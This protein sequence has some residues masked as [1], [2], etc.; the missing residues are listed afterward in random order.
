MLLSW[1]DDSLFQAVEEKST[2]QL[3]EEKIHCDTC[4]EAFT[5][6][7]FSHSHSDSLQYNVPC[8]VTR[9]SHPLTPTTSSHLVVFISWRGEGRR[10]LSL[11]LIMS[12]SASLS[13][14]TSSSSAP[15]TPSP[16]STR[17]I[18]YELRYGGEFPASA[19]VPM[20]PSLP[21]DQLR[22]AVF[23]AAGGLLPERYSYLALDVYP[24]GSS[25]D[26][27]S[28]HDRAVR[29]RDSIASVLDRATTPD[30]DTLILVARPLPPTAGVQGEKH[31]PGHSPQCALHVI[32][33]LLTDR[34]LAPCSPLLL[35]PVLGPV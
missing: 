20:D 21:I 6:T 13:S 12:S 35:L 16:P 5:I 29:P 1:G 15:P 11:S 18:A 32:T 7:D 28:D 17:F 31:R 10:T 33:L 30:D 2:V 26:V 19:L 23:A 4:D 22:Q 27:L 25:S 9:P 34:F 3:N 24:P 14:S 8:T